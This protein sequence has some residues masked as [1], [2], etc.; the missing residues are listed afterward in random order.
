MKSIKEKINEIINTKPWFDFE[1]IELKNKNAKIIGSTDFS[2]FHEI[3]IIIEDIYFVQCLDSWKSDTTSKV[4][5]IPEIE[6]QRDVNI[7]YEIEQGY[8]LIQ[9]LAEDVGP[10][11]FSCKDINYNSTKVTY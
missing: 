5:I 7:L 8:T 3:E 2:Y 10:I 11:Y 9:F 1:L 4:L 6:C